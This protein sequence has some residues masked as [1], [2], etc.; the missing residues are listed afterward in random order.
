MFPPEN[1]NDLPS[2]SSAIE[3]QSINSIVEIDPSKFLSSM[4]ALGKKSNVKTN[5]RIVIATIKF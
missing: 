5:C 4:M 2:T 1:T 3:S